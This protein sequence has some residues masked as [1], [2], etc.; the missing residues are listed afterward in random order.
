MKRLVVIT[1]VIFDPF[2][3][4]KGSKRGYDLFR[5]REK[6][7]DRDRETEREGRESRNVSK[8][9]LL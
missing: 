5:D 2:G 4:R 3:I 1:K 6:E 7:R 8:R 9:N